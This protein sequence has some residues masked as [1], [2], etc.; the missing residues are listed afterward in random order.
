[1]RF[2]I[3]GFSPFGKSKT[4]PSAE[5]VRLLPDTLGGHEIFRAEL[6]VVY[7][8]CWDELHSQILRVQPDCV[9][10]L[11]QAAGREGISLENTAV[12]VRASSEADNAGVTFSGEKIDEDGWFYSKEDVALYLWTYKKLPAN[13]ITKS[14]AQK[15]GW[16]GGSVQKYKDGAAIGGDRFGNYEG[17]LPKNKKYRECDIDT[18]GAKSRG[19][20]RIVFAEDYSAI[21]YT[22]DHY[23]SFTQLYPEEDGQ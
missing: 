20:K 18:D 22:D 1:M 17:L 16:E 15:L 9:L 14:A 11:G 21:Y 4:N 6:P 23:E 2:L 10:C 5:A 8:K 7:G 3:T 19:A 13:F 12:N